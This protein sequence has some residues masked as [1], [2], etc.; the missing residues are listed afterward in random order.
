[1]S[2]PFTGSKN[3]PSRIQREASSKHSSLCLLGVFFD[4]EDRG[5]M[6]FRNA[7]RLSTIDKPF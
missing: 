2:P 3:M 1:M 7:D 6:F 5:H 4:P